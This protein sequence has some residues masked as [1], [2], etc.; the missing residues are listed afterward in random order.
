M[1]HPQPP[2]NGD[3]QPTNARS[4]L[5][6]DLLPTEDLLTAPPLP[7]HG[8]LHARLLQHR[9]VINDVSRKEILV[10]EILQRRA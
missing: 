1:C 2:I 4:R 3:L 9:Y 6:K 10:I 7:R 5:A 8:P